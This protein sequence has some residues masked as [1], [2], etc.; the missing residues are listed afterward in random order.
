M[1]RFSA[2]L[3]ALL[4]VGAGNG[5]GFP[6]TASPRNSHSAEGYWKLVDV[7][8]GPVSPVDKNEKLDMERGRIQAVGSYENG[9]FRLSSTWT[10]PA[11]RYSAG[12]RVEITLRIKLEDFVW[13]TGAPEQFDESLM[14]GF[15][16]GQA[17]RDERNI[18]E[19]RVLTF[20]GDVINRTDSRTVS[21][22][23]PRGLPG[24]RMSILIRSLKFGNA[25]YTYEWV[26]PTVMEGSYWELATVDIQK[27]ADNAN[28]VSRLGRG[29]ASYLVFDPDERFQVFYWFTEPAERIYAGQKVDITLGARIDEYVWA[30]Q[31]NFMG[32]SINAG[33]LPGIPFKDSDGAWFAGVSGRQGKIVEGS[34]QRTVSG[35][36]PPGA[37]NGKA[38]FYVQCDKIGKILYHYRWVEI[39]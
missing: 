19:A 32:G 21:G 28:S 7:A 22:E 30:G 1:K 25:L 2:F 39:D 17:F 27:N 10:E 11:D 16:G 29:T 4:V 14:A 34:A 18:V 37:K 15:W 12:Q 38:V 33:F 8:L 26:E 9:M 23:F 24:N 20:F 3:L 36:F 31:F 5:I 35:K 13:M 6:E